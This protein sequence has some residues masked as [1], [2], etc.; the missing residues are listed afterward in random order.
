MAAVLSQGK[1]AEW[2]EEPACEMCDKPQG[3]IVPVAFSFTGRVAYDEENMSGK[4]AFL[5]ERCLGG[6]A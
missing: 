5:C 4:H 6:L 2:I 1:T 3:S